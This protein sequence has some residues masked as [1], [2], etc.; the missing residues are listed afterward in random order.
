MD[1][2]PSKLNFIVCGGNKVSIFD[3]RTGKSLF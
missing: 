2:Y 3:I 1:L